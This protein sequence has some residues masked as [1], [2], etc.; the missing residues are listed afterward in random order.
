MTNQLITRAHW[1]PI[2][3]HWCH[4]TSWVMPGLDESLSTGKLNKILVALIYLK[5]I[6]PLDNAILSFNNWG[7]TFIVLIHEWWCYGSYLWSPVMGGGVSIDALSW[8]AGLHH[9]LSGTGGGLLWWETIAS[10]FQSG[11]LVCSIV[12]TSSLTLSQ[13]TTLGTPFP[14]FRKN[15]M[16]PLKSHGVYRLRSWRFRYTSHPRTLGSLIIYEWNSKT[17]FSMVWLRCNCLRLNL[18]FVV[19]FFFPGTITS[20]SMTC[21]RTKLE[22]DIAVPSRDPSINMSEAMLRWWSSAQT[23][24]TV[25]RDSVFLTKQAKAALHPK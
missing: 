24:R 8:V 7:Q 5:V 20:L 25:K 19:D 23:P 3:F 22:S 2:D 1:L 16:S 4:W 6:F 13:T 21:W 18:C 9:R 14:F 10:V 12:L 11:S 15:R 17:V